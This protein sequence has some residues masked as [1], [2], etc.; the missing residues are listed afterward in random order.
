MQTCSSCSLPHFRSWQLHLSSCLEFIS[1]HLLSCSL[2]YSLCFFLSL[3]SP[4]IFNLSAKSVSSTCKIVDLLTAFQ[5]LHNNYHWD[6]SHQ[7]VSHGLLQQLSHLP[8]MFP[9]P[10]SLHAVY[11]QHIIQSDPIKH[12][13]VHVTPLFYLCNAS[14]CHAE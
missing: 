8:P 6:P 3:F 9:L 13:P 1:I 14:L 2:L 5:K 12:K 11:S 7:L 4:H 10:I